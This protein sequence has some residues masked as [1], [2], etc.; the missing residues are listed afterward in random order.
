MK[1]YSLLGWL[2]ANAV[3]WK[4]R[5]VSRNLDRTRVIWIFWV[6]W[7]FRLR[8]ISWLSSILTLA[9]ADVCWWLGRFPAH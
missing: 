9:P 2:Y 6:L 4:R 5:W 1:T 8:N 3:R 7:E